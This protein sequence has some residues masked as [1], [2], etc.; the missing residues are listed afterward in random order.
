LPSRKLATR[1]TLGAKEEAT[2]QIGFFITA[3]GFVRYPSVAIGRDGIQAHEEAKAVGQCVEAEV[4]K[5]RFAIV[6]GVHRFLFDEITVQ[7][8][9]VS[10]GA[11][12]SRSGH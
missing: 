6:G 8:S 5:V 2:I 9:A 11:Q 4:R 12:H 7:P 1:S 10:G 3:S